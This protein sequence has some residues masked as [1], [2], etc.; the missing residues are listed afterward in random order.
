MDYRGVLLVGHARAGRPSS[1]RR[2]PA[3]APIP[4]RSR[5]A[6]VRRGSSG[7]LTSGGTDQQARPT[8]AAADGGDADAG[9]DG[10][11]GRGDPVFG[12]TAFTR[13]P[14]TAPAA[15]KGAHNTART[16]TATRPA[17]L[18]QPPAVDL[19][20][21]NVGVRRDGLQR[22]GRH[23]ARGRGRDPRRPDPTARS[24]GRGLQR[25]GRQLLV[26]SVADGPRGQP[27]RRPQRDQGLNMAGTIARCSGRL[28]EG[29]LPRHGRRRPGL[30]E[31]APSSPRGHR[32]ARPACPCPCPC[33]CPRPCPSAP[34][35]VPM[36]E[37]HVED[38]RP[39]IA[40]RA[41]QRPLRD[42][43]PLEEQVRRV[44]LALREPGRVADLHLEVAP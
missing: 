17:G 38:R 4:G 40:A 6:S 24:S 20:T 2:R 34:A 15:A 37:E 5:S 41:D 27:R 35:S 44:G 31:V 30:P 19:D 11:S 23:R 32:R 22:R 3:A 13:G 26:G 16:R 7:E 42:E 28:P 39:A 12:T 10:G 1:A 21:R 29:R 14:P 25:R 43:L 33:P 8:A 18:H 36:L 9:A